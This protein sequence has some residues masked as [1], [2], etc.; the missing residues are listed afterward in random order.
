MNII[1]IISNK[2]WGGGER[3]ALDLCRALEDR[4]H[5]TAVITRKGHPEVDRPFEHAGIAVGHLPL[6]GAIDILSP[7]IL[8]RIL[9]RI[10]PPVVIHV[11][12]FKDAIVALRARKLMKADKEQVKVVC[13]RH[14]VRAAKTGRLDRNTYRDL[15]AIIFVSDCA[16]QQFLSTASAELRESPRIHTVHNSILI[17]ENP[18]LQAA[19]ATDAESDTPFRFI[20]AGRLSPEKGFDT[21]VEAFAKVEAARPGRARLTICGTGDSRIVMPVVKRARALGID[22]K[23]SWP[24]HVND[25]YPSIRESQAGVIPSRAPEAFGLT[26]LEFMSQGLPV[27]ASRIGALPEI[28]RPGEDG[29]LVEPDNADALAEAMIKLI[30]N[31]QEAA[32]MGRTA[33]VRARTAFGY[34]TFIDRI[35]SIYADPEK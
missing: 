23:I 8:S 26:A 25:I 3:Y 15:D 30:D 2:V 14:L 17:P 33:A 27:V 35:L 32:R 12:N 20:F 11:H 34:D 10:E 18:D 29:L 22:T 19:D 21:L 6:R 4:G 24:G 5:S 13:T 31:P 9:D 7:T 16:R 1:H 28:I